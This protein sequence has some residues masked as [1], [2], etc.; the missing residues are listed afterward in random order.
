MKRRDFVRLSAGAALAVPFATRWAFATGASDVAA[1]TLAG[2]TVTLTGTDL[3][4]LAASLR[5]SVLLSG[6]AGYDTARKLWNGMFDRHPALIVRCASPADVMST[7]DFARAHKLLTAVR[8]GGHS[9]T[10]RSACDG[11]LMID[12]SQMRAARVDPDAR[13]ARVE[14]GALLGDLDH[15]TR[16]FGLVTTAGTVSHT[17]AGGLTLGGGLGRVG[18]R[19]G[20]TCDNLIGADVITADGRRVHTGEQ[21][22]PDLLW[23]LRGGGGNFGVVTSLEY[24]LHAMDPTILG[25]LV[26]WPIEQ[27]REV[28]TFFADFSHTSPDEL[29][30]DI[31][32]VQPPGAPPML[33]IEFC[34]SGDPRRGEAAMAPLRNVGKPIRD[35]VQPMLYVDLQRS[36]DEANDYGTRHYAKAAFSDRLDAE[37]IDALVDAFLTAPQDLTVVLQQAG[38]AINRV[39]PDATAFVNRNARCWMMVMSNWR[40][41]AEDERRMANTRRAWQGVESMA[42]GY[43]TNALTND[44]ESRAKLVYGGNYDR[45]VTLKNRYDPGNL[46]QL[47]AN[48][49]P[50]IKLAG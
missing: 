13:T 37:S 10:G 41:P 48:V 44:E 42:S 25:G 1:R 27:A 15:E 49:K 34:W 36:G 16:P 2:E 12:L 39:A 50:T 8:G 32:M 30:T 21:D 23:G 43:Y 35:T 31:A 20:L 3:S 7:V 33:G 22:N 47:N 17:G 40:D 28:L 6:D 5:G 9:A 4:N 14:G 46:F 18:R 19:F 29:N 26:M 11:G 38:G 45:L 24:R